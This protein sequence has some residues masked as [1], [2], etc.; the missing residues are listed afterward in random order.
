MS[1]EVAKGIVRLSAATTPVERLGFRP[2]AVVLWWCCDP[3]A[4]CRGGI[5]FATDGGGEAATGW[6]A[7][8]AL[9][10]GVL[11]RVGADTAV[12]LYESP[13]DPDSAPRGRIR[14]VDQGFSFE[15]DRTPQDP[16]LVHYFAV[17]GSDV[18]GAAVRSLM[19][20]DSGTRSVT[21]LNFAPGIVVAV[22]G[23]GAAA[24]AAR[25]GLAIAFGAAAGPS[26][27]VA[28]GFVADAE[29]GKTIVRGA[30]CTDALAAL[31]AADGSDGMGAVT[32]LVSLDQDGFTIETTHSK[33]DLPLAVLALAGDGYSVGLGK[34]ASRTT[35]VD[36]EPAGALLFGTGLAAMPRPRD[37]GRMCLGGFSHAKDTGCLSWSVRAHGAWPLEPRSRSS[38][39]VAF[40]VLDTTSDELHARATL[41]GLGRRGFSLAWPVSDPYRRDFGYVAFG[42]K[43]QRP[44]LGNLLRV[45]GRRGSLGE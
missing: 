38:T 22:A 35:G 37:I 33:F 32:R 1:F 34:A 42:T 20:D 13:S 9:N 23:G 43:P 12:L 25:A 2:R 27:Q 39:D 6:I 18:R 19:L 40:E 17:G 26:R 7:D 10:P 36:L 30:Q 44:R 14:F 31:P 29:A 28:G 11:S 15:C 16:W 21:G 4:G 24:G 45:L 8:D 41:S 5:G 3:P